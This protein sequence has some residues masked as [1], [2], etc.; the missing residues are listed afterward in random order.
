MKWPGRCLLLFLSVLSGN[1]TTALPLTFNFRPLFFYNSNSLFWWQTWQLVRQCCKPN[2]NNKGLLGRNT[3]PQSILISS[4]KT[5]WCHTGS[6]WKQNFKSSD[7]FRR[8]YRVKPLHWISGC[9]DQ[10]RL[11]S[12]TL[13]LPPFFQHPQS[14][15]R[16]HFLGLRKPPRY[17]VSV[18]AKAIF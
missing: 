18:M 4:T 1:V 6:I 10:P 9:S 7:E 14:L 16:E 3:A 13:L 8:N 15:G 11:L 5:H 2:P 17:L 12:A